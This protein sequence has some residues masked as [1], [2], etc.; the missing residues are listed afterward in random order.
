MNGNLA[1]VQSTK[2]WGAG[3]GVAKEF[4]P[5]RL[6]PASAGGIDRLP[7]VSV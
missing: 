1:V 3:D 7:D 6:G 2:L 5:L 4:Q